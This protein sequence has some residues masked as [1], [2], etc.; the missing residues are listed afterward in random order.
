M[1]GEWEWEVNRRGMGNQK[2]REMAMDGWMDGGA[3]AMDGCESDI[4]YM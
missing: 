4:Q 2:K 3:E 1:G